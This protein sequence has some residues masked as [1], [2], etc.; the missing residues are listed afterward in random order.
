MNERKAYLPE[1]IRA[2]YL[3]DTSFR[4]GADRRHATVLGARHF[5]ELSWAAPRR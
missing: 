1:C 4:E 3:C 2:V 5:T